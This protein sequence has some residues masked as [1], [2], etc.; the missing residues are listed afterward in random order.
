MS[1][2]KTDKGSDKMSEI[3]KKLKSQSGETFIE[4]LSALIIV[5]FATIL[6]ASLVI[7]SN[8]LNDTQKAADSAF[9]KAVAECE[10]VSDT[11]KDYSD[12]YITDKTGIQ[13]EKIKCA[14]SSHDGLTSYI[15]EAGE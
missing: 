12:V 2:T 5:S 6:F 14:T 4:I 15:K 13:L 11:D 10:A 3:I 1:I 9:Y 7:A 8:K